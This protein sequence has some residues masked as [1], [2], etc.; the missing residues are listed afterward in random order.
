[1]AGSETDLL[2]LLTGELKNWE[3]HGKQPRLFLRDDDAVDVSPA[4]V[5]LCNLSE[6]SN[7]PLLLAVIPGL[8]SDRL[9]AFVSDH[10]LLTPAVH[11]Y[12]HRNH[13]P[14]GGKKC[15]FGDERN[16]CDILEELT[17]G[18]QILCDLFED[19]ISSLF[20]PPWNRIGEKGVEACHAAG[21]SG[22]SGFGWKKRN[23]AP[24]KANTHL[25][26]IDWEHDKA[27]KTTDEIIDELV[28]NL[29]M[30]RQNNFAPVGVLTHHLVHNSLTWE[31]LERFIVIVNELGFR[32][33]DISDNTTPR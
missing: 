21:F 1:M 22:I 18:R 27:A 32:W 5:E 9:G 26:V 15:E 24:I 7:I 4:L 29:Q 25:D 8:A 13:A 17:T 30:A 11:G 33:I 14:E 19:K 23:S 28:L 12:Y 2:P 31:A 10:P 3:Q 6:N 20:V 16:Y